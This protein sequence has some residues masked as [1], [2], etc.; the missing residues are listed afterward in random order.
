MKRSAAAVAVCLLTTAAWAGDREIS[1]KEGERR[2]FKLPGIAQ[3][4]VDDAQVVEG[5][6]RGDS[7][8]VEA[9]RE[10]TARIMVLLKSDQWV[11]FRIKVVPGDVPSGPIAE[12]LPGE[13]EVL[14][15][16]LG[17]RRAF[18]TPGI[19]KMPL[20]TQGAF[21]AKVTGKLLELRGV[22]PGRAMLELQL[23]GGKRLLV[24]VVVEPEVV[25]EVQA[26]VRR[27]DLLNGESVN[28]PENG[29]QLVKVPD[30]EAVSVED[31][32][33][34]E[35]RIVGDGRVVVRGINEGDTRMVVRRA[36]RAYA[37]PVVVTAQPE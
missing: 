10:G 15:L 4:A 34:A 30:L 26:P 33:V 23:N 7:I 5:I 17:E 9:R 19:A 8:D 20:N 18:E 12:A 16:R 2:S 14:R 25:H 6:G 11:T 21:E 28:V 31:D 36:G 32:E 1:M 13:G 29:E 37:Y 24:P 3:I 27:A 22:T 35:V